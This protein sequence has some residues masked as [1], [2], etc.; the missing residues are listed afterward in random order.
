MIDARYGN[1]HMKD[2]VEKENH[3]IGPKI[4]LGVLGVAGVYWVFEILLYFASNG[5]PTLSGILIGSS[6]TEIMRRLVV[7]IF[8]IIIGSH[9]QYTIQK[10][11]QAER[12]LLKAKEE[13]DKLRALSMSLSTELNLDRLLDKILNISTEL[14]TADRGTLFMHDAKTGSLKAIIAHGVERRELYIPSQ[15]GLAGAA[16]TS[17]TTINIKDAYEDSRFNREIDKQT[18]Y[19][20]KSVLCVPV[21]DKKGRVMGVLQFINKREGD[22]TEYDEKRIETFA[23]SVSIALENARLFDDVLSLKNYNERVLESMSNGVV[24]IDND[25]RVVKCNASALRILDDD[26]AGII[27]WTTEEYFEPWILDSVRRVMSTG[28]PELIMDTDIAL[29]RGGQVTINLNVVPLL[30]S[31]KNIIGSL[32]ILEDITAEKRLKSTLTRYMSKEVADKLMQSGELILGGETRE[33][34]I[35]FSDIKGFTSIAERSSPHEIVT[36][37]NDYFTIMVDIVFSHKGILDKY[38][39]DAL[40]AVF[41]APLASRE[42]PDNAVRAAI[43]MMEALN[44]FNRIRVL[45][46]KELLQ[47]RIGINTNEVLSGNI[48]SIKRMDYTVIGDGVNIAARLEQINKYF[49]T[50]ILISEFTRKKLKGDYL[51]RKVD[52]IRVKGKSKPVMIYQVMDHYTEET[53]PNLSDVLVNY[54]EG[55]EYYES[56]DWEK[57]A[58]CFERALQYNS[59]D[60]LPQFYLDRCLYFMDIP[61]EEDWDGVWIVREAPKA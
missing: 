45:D 17:G 21:K 48:G 56:R 20:T 39:G 34:T 14:L 37:L 31:K 3:S 16:F 9:I 7:L 59:K 57:A 60:N 4:I 46:E 24:S 8:F 51:M 10:R 27:G 32:L 49:D 42:D 11:E 2:N 5:H 6:T 30:D 29:A 28:E 43:Q 15:S 19:K 25:E 41:G 35:L 54:N 47:I 12:A 53:F 13:E 1:L 40:M 26:A 50:N 52:L 33:A 38:I 36:M 22:F 23:A 61:P 44:E 18:G 55:L 58:K